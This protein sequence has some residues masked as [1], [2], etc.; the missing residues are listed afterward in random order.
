V[1]SDTSLTARMDVRRGGGLSLRD[2]PDLR[3]S[4]L[5]GGRYSI[6]VELIDR[7]SRRARLTGDSLSTVLAPTD[8]AFARLPAASLERLRADSAYREQWLAGV[9]IN[10]SLGMRDLLRVGTA[11]SLRGTGLAVV[12]GKDGL[13]RVGAARVVQPDLVARNGTLHGLD[14]VLLP[15]TTSA[16]P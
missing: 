9:L 11:R 10:G 16:S 7:S 15:E 3:S 4:A 2:F 8:S 12:R 1:S 14:R 5:M 6:L 13:N